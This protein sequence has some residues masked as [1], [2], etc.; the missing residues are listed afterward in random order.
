MK[1]NLALVTLFYLPVMLTI[2]FLHLTPYNWTE[3]ITKPLAI[4]V[5]IYFLKNSGSNLPMGLKKG[6]FLGLIFFYLSDLSFLLLAFVNEWFIIG[7]YIFSLLAM[8]NISIGFQHTQTKFLP[9]FD[10]KSITPLNLFLS[11]L[12]VIFP[13]S[14]FIIE[15]LEL[16]QYP[17]IV[18]Q[19]IL[20]AL[21]S[22]SLRRQDHVNETSY[23]M[24][25]AG[26]VLYTITTM[27]LTLQNFTNSTFDFK[28]LP[29]L[30]YFSSLFLTVTGA[31]VQGYTPS[32]QKNN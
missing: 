12:I 21:I 5:L 4:I 26:I 13:I 29:V 10:F 31:V 3:F 23:Y 27:L 30:T 11:T 22:Q 24:V 19:G 2:Y 16:W 9:F 25:L 28:S 1:K 32:S 7:T 17:A 15:D 8:Y 18:Y 20:W 14:I 6:I